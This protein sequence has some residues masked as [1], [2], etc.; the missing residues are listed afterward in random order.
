MKLLTVHAIALAFAAA[1]S[2]AAQ[3][4]A[5]LP[6]ATVLAASA[7]GKGVVAGKV[8]VS[9]TVVAIDAAARTVTLKGAKGN[10]VD[11]VVPPEAKNFSEIRVGDL[12]TVD[13]VRALTL[14]LKPSG[15]LRSSTTETATAP[16]PAGAVAG[17]HRGQRQG[18]LCHAARP[19]GQQRRSVGGPVT[20]EA[21]EGGRPGR[22]GLHRGHGRDRAA[23]QEGRGQ[24]SPCGPARAGRSAALG[25]A[26][27]SGR[28]SPA[29]RHPRATRHRA[30]RRRAGT[31][32]ARRQSRGCR[33]RPARRA[34]PRCNEW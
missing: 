16:V 26:R 20:A 17:R 32:T 19:Q 29:P 31:A 1:F 28:W 10:V 27:R 24:V 14:Q 9:A 22:G 8:T 34:G 13:Y 7:P 23:R 3:A 15:G 18:R 2:T 21:G 33:P 5:A 6:Q 11:V 30:S 12:V 25:A 4:Q